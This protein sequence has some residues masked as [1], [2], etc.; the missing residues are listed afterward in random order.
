[1]YIRT[2]LRRT[3]YIKMLKDMTQIELWNKFISDANMEALSQI[4][5]HYYDLL[6]DYGQKHTSDKQLVE[7]TVQEVFI[8]LI[9][10]RKN[11]GIVKS[12]DAYL[13]S[14]FRRQLFLDL[15]KQK[16]TILTERLPEEH[17]DYFKSPNQDISEGENMERLHSTIKQCISKLT[18][19]QREIIFLRFEREISYEEI[20]ETL[21]ISVDSCYKLTYRTIK[22]IRSEVEKILGKGANIFLLILFRTHYRS[23]KSQ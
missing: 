17:F 1:M 15:N 13:I 7:D 16:K 18:D 4:Y 14:A 3:N 5:F 21:N 23:I 2:L 19:K 12:L 8:N 6:F 20:A 10:H 11:I 22:T 9:K